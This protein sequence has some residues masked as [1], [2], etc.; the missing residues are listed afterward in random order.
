MAPNRP[1]PPRTD[2]YPY[3]RDWRTR[4]AALKPTEDDYP[5]GGVIGVALAWFVAGILV[6][7]AA[8]AFLIW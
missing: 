5:C 1:E 3:I 7:A 2:I 8:A 6:M 4:I